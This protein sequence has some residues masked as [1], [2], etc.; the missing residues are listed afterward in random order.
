MAF[1]HPV[2]GEKLHFRAPIWEDML[3]ILDS[4]AAGEGV[5]P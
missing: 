1:I 5:S 2:T 4:L 3:E